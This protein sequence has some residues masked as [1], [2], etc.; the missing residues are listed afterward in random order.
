M[1]WSATADGQQYGARSH[2]YVGV[3]RSSLIG[4]YA[5]IPPDAG[6]TG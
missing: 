1:W 6:P 5:D 4:L 2:G 3:I